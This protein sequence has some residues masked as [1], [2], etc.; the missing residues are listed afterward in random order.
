MQLNI[1]IS[2]GIAAIHLRQGDRF[3]SAF[4]RNSSTDSTLKELLKS[5]HICQSYL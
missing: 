5:A 2:Q 1:H 4:F 3:Y